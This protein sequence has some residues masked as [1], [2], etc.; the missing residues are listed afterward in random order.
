[1]TTAS[2]KSVAAIH[3]TPANVRF[4]SIVTSVAGFCCLPDERR[5]WGG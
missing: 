2:A 5:L 3:A 1:M 4:V